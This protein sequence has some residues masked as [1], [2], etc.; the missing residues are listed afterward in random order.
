MRRNLLGLDDINADINANIK[1]D[2]ETLGNL[3]LIGFG[4]VIINLALN[5][6]IS[7]LTK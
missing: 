4:L 7:V 6:T 5:S 1:L 2:N 3:F